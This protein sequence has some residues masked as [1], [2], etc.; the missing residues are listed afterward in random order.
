MFLRR[1][2]DVVA[3]AG[4]ED[5]LLKVSGQWVSTL[6]IEHAL[7]EA[8]GDA[9]DQVA[10]IGVPTGDGLTAISALAVAVPGREDEARR[11]LDAAIEGLPKY[12]RPCW[13]HWVSELPLTATGKLQRSCLREAH[14]SALSAR[15]G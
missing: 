8:G 5:D 13:V 4:R 14:E 2:G 7:A 6:W 11:R 15:N 1:S 12:R 9:I 3:F 10:A